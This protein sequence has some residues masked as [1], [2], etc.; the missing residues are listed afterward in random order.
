MNDGKV[1]EK[2]VS[3]ELA[4]KMAINALK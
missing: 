2:Y 4:D 3:E 1:P